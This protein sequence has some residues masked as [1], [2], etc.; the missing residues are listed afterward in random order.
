M[1]LLGAC[2]DYPRDV[3]GTTKRLEQGSVLRVGIVAG[4]VLSAEAEA[5]LEQLAA[6]FRVETKRIAAPAEI[7]IDQ[8]DEGEIDLVVGVF[9]KRSVVKEDVSLSRRIG[10]PEPDDGKRP[11]LRLARKHGENHWILLT[12]Q[13]VQ[14]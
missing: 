4:T 8:L 2:Q 1:L 12:D 9:A 11:V 7:L 3:E 14:P 13:V 10:V 5:A 6:R